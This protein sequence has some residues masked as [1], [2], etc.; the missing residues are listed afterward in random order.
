MLHAVMLSCGHIAPSDE[1]AVLLP[2]VPTRCCAFDA[3]GNKKETLYYQQWMDDGGVKAKFSKE[4][5]A[6]IC[7][8]LSGATLTEPQKKQLKADPVFQSCVQASNG[9]MGARI[10]GELLV[11]LP[12]KSMWLRSEDDKHASKS[13]R[14]VDDYVRWFDVEAGVDVVVTNPAVEERRRETER[15]E[16]DARE[17]KEREERAARAALQTA[18]G[19]AKKE[20]APR[21]FSCMEIFVKTLTGKTITLRDVSSSDTIDNIKQKIQDQEGIPPDQQRLVFAGK[22]LEDGRTLLDYN[23]QKES[24]LHCILRLRGGMYNASSSREDFLDLGGV[25]ESEVVPV[26][27]GPGK[28]VRAVEIGP[29]DQAKDVIDEIVGAARAELDDAEDEILRQL[30]QLELERVERAKRGGSGK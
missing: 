20:G 26:R 18:T 3:V 7:S 5:R 12:T 15:Q 23:I 9:K 29:K 6:S 21:F 22:Q 24:T 17:K 28:A 11:D 4:D 2:P 1:I 19:A 8:N 13:E 27:F 25:I 16:R 30:L 14:K 10:S